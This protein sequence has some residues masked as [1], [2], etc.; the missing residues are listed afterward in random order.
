LIMPTSGHGATELRTKVA[1]K[2]EIH[3]QLAHSVV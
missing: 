1:I 3:A 2:R